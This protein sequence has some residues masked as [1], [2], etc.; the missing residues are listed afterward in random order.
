MLQ[1]L[2][3]QVSPNFAE[4]ELTFLE[5]QPIDLAKAI[6]QHRAYEACLSA[7]GVQVISLPADPSFPDAVFVHLVRDPRPTISSLVEGWRSRRFLA[8]RGM[9]GWPY[10]D[11]SFLL[12]PGWPA[13]A[14]CSL[15]E[16]AAHQWQ[17]ANATIEDDLRAAPPGSFCKVDYD[18][19]VRDPREIMHR[20]AALARLGW[21]DE[22]EAAV[23]AALPLSRVT[24]SAPAPHKWWQHEAQLAALLPQ[25]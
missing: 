14:G 12:P 3:R 25:R 17:V 21:D 8:Y 10:R 22:V 16:I 4:C 23:S 7:L 20:I 18:D 5:R 15:V 9:P 13:L 2:T 24:L 11:W 19:L 6:A 1:A